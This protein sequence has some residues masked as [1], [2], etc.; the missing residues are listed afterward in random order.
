MFPLH[1]IDG[2][3]PTNCFD[4]DVMFID[5]CLKTL[6]GQMLNYNGFAFRESRDSDDLCCLHRSKAFL[7]DLINPFHQLSSDSS[8][9]CES[10]ALCVELVGSRFLRYYS[11]IISYN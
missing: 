1:R 10:P 9:H 3:S 11:S 8:E 4:V 5:S 2:P 7:V 6:E